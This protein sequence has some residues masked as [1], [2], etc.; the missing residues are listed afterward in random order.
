M[1]I[2]PSSLSNYKLVTSDLSDIQYLY[3]CSDGSSL[4]VRIVL[5]QLRHN[6]CDRNNANSCDR[7]FAMLRQ[8]NVTII[9]TV[10]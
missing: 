9:V 7:A 6:V 10:T 1:L 5:Q 2:E 4:I 3:N 8:C